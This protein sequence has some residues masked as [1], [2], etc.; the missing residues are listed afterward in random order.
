MSSR[1]QASHQ[2][3]TGTKKTPTHPSSELGAKESLCQGATVTS[4]KGP[5][6]RMKQ[7][8][9]RGFLRFGRVA[10]LENP[11][12]CRLRDVLLKRTPDRMLLRQAEEIVS[13][14]V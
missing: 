1:D 7:R 3:E 6:R 8:E 10:Q 4:R 9:S 14:E 11:L 2:P 13:Y 12:L 5:I